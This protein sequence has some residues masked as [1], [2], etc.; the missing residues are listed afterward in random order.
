MTKGGSLDERERLETLL[1]AVGVSKRRIAEALP[2]LTGD[3]DP[4]RLLS[5]AETRKVLGCSR[6]GIEKL[7]GIGVTLD[8]LVRALLTGEV[9]SGGVTVEREPEAEGLPVRLKVLEGG[10]ALRLVL[11]RFK[12]LAGPE[13]A[14]GTGEPPPGVEL[15]PIDLL[16]PVS[17]ADEAGREAR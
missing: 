16:E 9:A 7:I 10:R 8:D 11:K 13:A 15:L 6:Y 1:E 5:L 12:P 3:P 14:L 17:Y 2:I 4:D